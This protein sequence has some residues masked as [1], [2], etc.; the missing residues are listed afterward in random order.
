[1]LVVGKV[2][3]RCVG[4]TADSKAVEVHCRSAPPASSSVGVVLQAAVPKIIHEAL[5]M[6]AI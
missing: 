1:M 4:G 3:E 2:A 6:A 5:T